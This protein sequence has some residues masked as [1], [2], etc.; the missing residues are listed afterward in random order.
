MKISQKTSS[1]WVWDE[2]LKIKNSNKYNR[3]IT[4]LMTMGENKYVIIF[5]FSFYLYYIMLKI[6]NNTD[7]FNC[8][9]YSS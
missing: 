9:R 2:L 1:L 8:K 3:H 6:K 4:K 5:V 7:F